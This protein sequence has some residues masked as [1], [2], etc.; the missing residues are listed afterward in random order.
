MT[1]R[2]INLGSLL[3]EALG[4]SIGLWC[5]GMSPRRQ[6][7]FGPYRQRFFFGKGDAW[8]PPTAS[9]LW[10]NRRIIELQEVCGII[11]NH[12]HLFFVSL[13]HDNGGISIDRQKLRQQ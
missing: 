12:L 1:R 8:L 11:A 10:M 2:D 3:G 13:M 5:E 9:A 6:R 7:R 4:D